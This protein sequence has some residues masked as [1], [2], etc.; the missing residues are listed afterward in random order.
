MVLKVPNWAGLRAERNQ[1]FLCCLVFSS[2]SFLHPF[3]NIT[4]SSAGASVAWT[5]SDLSEHTHAR[6]HAYSEPCRRA[7]NILFTAGLFKALLFPPKREREGENR[8]SERRLAALTP[9]P[10]PH[11]LHLCF[12][13]Q[14]RRGAALCVSHGCVR[15]LL[16]LKRSAAPLT[17]SLSSIHTCTMTPTFPPSV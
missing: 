11:H 4:C 10:P 17:P 16:G 7:D 3:P 14:V 13:P 9:P 1:T 5:P 6:T 2:L 12:L 15:L 8:R